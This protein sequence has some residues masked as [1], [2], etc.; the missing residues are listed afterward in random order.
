MRRDD[1]V[2]VALEQ[3][4]VGDR[5]GRE[6]VERRAGDLAGVERVLERLVDQQLA[7]GAVDDPHA[8]AHLRE[9]LGVQP[10]ARL[11]RL[12][13]VD[14]DE[15]GL[16]VDVAARLGLLDAELAEALGGDERVEGEHAHAEALGAGGDELADA[17]EAEDA[18]RLLVDLDAAELRALPLAGGEAGVRLRDVARQ[19]QH[20]RDGVLRGGD[21]VRLRRVGDDDPALGG[22]LD[23]DVVDPDAGA[24]D[25]LEVVGAA[26]Q[27]GGQLASPSG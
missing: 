7:A 11:G 5:L 26:D 15:V 20:Q 9:R 3:R 10:A 16:A 1:D 18:E 23:V 22:R 17:A 6:D 19:R 21:D 12:R 13:Q 27:V 14:G 2:V 8:V 4:V 25:D 24:A